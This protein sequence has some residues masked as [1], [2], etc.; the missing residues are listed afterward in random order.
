MTDRAVCITGYGLLSPLGET[1]AAW[2]AALSDS[3]ARRARID[4]AATAP[5][6]IH[7]IGDYD[8]AAQVPRPGDRRAMG[9]MMQYGAYAAGLA[10]DMAGLKGDDDLLRQTHMIV[11]SGG[12]ERDLEL[13]RQILEGA[14][15]RGERGARDEWITAQMADGLR[16]TLF[17][18]QLPNL[19][20]GNIS[21]VHKVAG[22]SRTF[23]GEEAAGADALRIAHRRLA[24][25][26]GE[27]FLVGAAFASERPEIQISYIAGGLLLRG[28]CA[29]L[30]S[31]PYAGIC[32][33]AA[34]AFL[35]LESRE[36]AAARDVAV[37]A[38][39]RGVESDRTDRRT[40][41]PAA[42]A[43]RQ[44]ERLGAG[45]AGPDTAVLSGA[46]GAGAATGITAAER[47]MLEDLAAGA[48][49]RGTAQAVG[50]AVEAAFLQNVILAAA[51][52]ERGEVFAPL[53]PDA[54]VEAVGAGPVSH[55]LVT[56]WGH[57]RGE[58][59]ALVEGTG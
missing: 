57:V 23:M 55:A 45:P 26:Q 50:H 56:G 51:C 35:V 30:W 39:L 1:P 14:P 40:G 38:V 13:D 9:P 54:P 22:S 42:T 48:P 21:I 49:V 46:S 17:L 16:P 29:A 41:D 5:F 10:L 19:F 44:L 52:V 53:S 28:G 59:L 36:S 2:W 25:G 15:G 12:G 32:F 43:R 6:P 3:V 11:A 47:A 31:G 7:T 58:A 18:A 27:I 4:E 33:G 24:S 34:G 20:A 37:R 8:L